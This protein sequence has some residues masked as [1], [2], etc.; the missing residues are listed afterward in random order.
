MYKYYSKYYT[1]ENEA[2]GIVS[3][4]LKEGDIFAENRL[5]L[6]KYRSII[7]P[8]FWEKNIILGIIC[9]CD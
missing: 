5:I 9:V 8:I 6:R 3:K 2:L 7:F 1:N 4:G